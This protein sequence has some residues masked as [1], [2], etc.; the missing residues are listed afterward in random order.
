MYQRPLARRLIRSCGLL[1]ILFAGGAMALPPASP[2]GL[3]PHRA[4]YDLSL[5]L[6]ES[7]DTVSD[8]EGRLVY[9]FSG[10]SCDGYTTRMRLVTRVTDDDGNTRLTDVTTTAFEDERSQNF[11]FT[12]KRFVDGSMAEEATGTAER[13]D[14]RVQIKLAKPKVERFQIPSKFRFPNQHLEQIVEAALRGDHFMQVDL[15]DGSG[16]GNTTYETTVVIGTLNTGADDL[17]D[18]AVMRQAGLDG[19]RHWPVTVS[20]FDKPSKGEQSPAYELS[21]ILYENGVTRR[22]R[23][24]Y[25]DFAL[26][27]KLVRLDIAPTKVGSK[28]CP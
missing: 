18:E 26:M 24:D 4:V 11:N 17:G 16:D 10:T 25:G 1:A 6:D 22:M 13:T 15:F 3:L 8:A 23:F 20:Y 7:S 14:D 21:F 19:T 2:P 5:D 9:D 27:G 28:R 12:S